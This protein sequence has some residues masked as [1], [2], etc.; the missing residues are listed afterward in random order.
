MSK[1]L[2]RGKKKVKFSRLIVISPGSRPNQGILAPYSK[3]SPKP[4]RI[5]PKTTNILPNSLTLAP[6]REIT[7]QNNLRP[8]RFR[9]KRRV[10][11]QRGAY[12][13]S[14]FK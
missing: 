9:H 7:R 5:N 12:H 10:S 3:I 8:H 11:A 1:E 4:I 13:C 2:T 6:P 14:A